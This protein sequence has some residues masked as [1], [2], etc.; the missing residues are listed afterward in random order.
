M[1]QEFTQEIENTAR[2][3]ANEIHTA[4]PGKITSFDAEKGIVSV[5]PYG[6]YVTSD[7]KELNYPVISDVPLVFPMSL[8]AKAGIAFPV[9]PG[10]SCL[11][12]ISEVELDA[13]RSGAESESSLR[14]DLSSAVAI[15]GLLSNGGSLLSDA[16]T[17]EAVIVGMENAKVFLSK[18]QIKLGVGTDTVVEV[19][20]NNVKIDIGQT[21]V[22]EASDSGIAIGGN[23]KV[24]GNITYTGS[25]SG[26]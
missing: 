4:L 26:G 9:K 14:Y 8:S 2:E 23:L 18:E 24:K 17:K 19:L 11:V 21:T 16:C 12:V 6:K 20:E 25:L 3:V 13:W 1:L 22:L 5:K 15:P 10:E 7:G